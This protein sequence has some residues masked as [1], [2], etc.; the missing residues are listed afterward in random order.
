MT[1]KIIARMRMSKNMPSSVYFYNNVDDKENSCKNEN[2][3]KHIKIDIFL[4][5]IT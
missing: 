5:I 4:C 1:R 2:E 3:Q